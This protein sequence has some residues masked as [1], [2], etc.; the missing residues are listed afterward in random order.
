VGYTS[1]VRVPDWLFDGENYHD[2]LL[3]QYVL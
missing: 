3:F 2:A 1:S